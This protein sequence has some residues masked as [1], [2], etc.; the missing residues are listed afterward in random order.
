MSLFIRSSVDPNRSASYGSC[1]RIWSLSF[2][3]G[4]RRLN[5][6]W[7]KERDGASDHLSDLQPGQ[8]DRDWGRFLIQRQP[9]T[10][11]GSK[12]SVVH[13][14]DLRSD[15]LLKLPER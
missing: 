10:D 15:G 14:I 1:G 3:R 7:A 8:L 11:L 6:N 9:P 13:T 4:Y 2:G 12:S 5:C